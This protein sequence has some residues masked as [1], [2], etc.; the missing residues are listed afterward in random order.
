MNQYRLTIIVQTA[1]SPPPKLRVGA[2]MHN[3]IHLVVIGLALWLFLLAASAQAEGE[4]PR[5]QPSP[6]SATLEVQPPAVFP[7]SP[8]TYTLT[9]SN[10]GAIDNQ[11]IISATLPA[12]VELPLTALPAGV[13]YN[14][15]S[16]RLNWE[17]VLA[18]GSSRSLVFPGLAPLE[19]PA[20][21]Q[22]T[23]YVALD[24]GEQVSH[25]SA[26]GWVG[27][28]PT[29]AFTYTPGSA[30]QFT[31]QSQGTGP[32]STWWEFG[33]GATSTEAN[34]S[35]SYPA[36]GEYTARLT[37]ANP[38]GANSVAQTVL[39]A[40]PPVPNVQPPLFEVLI[41]DDT[42]A[43]EQPIYF[44]NPSESISVTIRWNFG[45]GAASDLKNPTHIYQQPGVY[46]IT[47]VLGQGAAAIQ[48]SRILVVDYSP[49]ASIRVA[50]PVVS[51]GELLT[52]TA[53][54][55]APEVK[56]Y[57]WD[58]GDGNSARHNYVAH[59]YAAP[60]NFP[61]TLAVSN[62]FGVA[63]DTLTLQVSP[64]LVYLPLIMNLP[65]PPAE[66]A[67]TEEPEPEP[68]AVEAPPAE[69]ELVVAIPDDPLA[70]Q[71]LQAINAEREAAGLPPLVW[72]EQLTRSAQH[73]TSDM[74]T[75][76]FTGHYGSNG[77]RPVDR[78]RQANYTGDYAGECTAWGFDNLASAVAW[79]MTS[80]PHRVII[81]STVATEIG[82][83]YSYNPNA[84]SVHYWTV[85]FGAH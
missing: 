16:G 27:V 61:V 15:R 35:H 60:G 19:P 70:Q 52:F 67:A 9:L 23:A 68:A 14:L 31:N 37:V 17:G 55:S 56:S 59:S 33:D 54:T 48:S 11:V 72:S 65:M 71:V 42:P 50:R 82:G 80:P 1:L 49:Q 25:L 40:P 26:T 53:M 24:N 66:L 39:F 83:A 10:G 47:R 81:L 63:L 38:K 20:E 46:T 45:D 29:A 7:G 34:P 84:P 5:T 64:A 2:A 13:S 85:D 22:L 62:D 43:V 3:F 76:W 79:W 30:V 28:L 69:P 4:A 36:G 41:S 21:G 74:A 12:G 32:L 8:I 73:H 58:F 6:F 51:V 75:Y 18:A 57:Y 78:M 77:S 44:G